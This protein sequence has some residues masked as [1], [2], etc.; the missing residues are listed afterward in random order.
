[1]DHAWP[2][3]ALAHSIWGSCP[4]IFGVEGEPSHP[5]LDKNGSNP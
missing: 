5:P 4:T 2:C 3:H 1:M